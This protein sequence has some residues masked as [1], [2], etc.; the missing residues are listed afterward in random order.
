MFVG[1]LLFA[2]CCLMRAAWCSLFVI[3]CLL[4]VVRCSVIRGRSVLLRRLLL[5]GVSCSFCG[6][7]CVICCASCVA[8]CV[9]CFVLCFVFCVL[10]LLTDG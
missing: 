1:C 5:L 2:V 3:C 10:R 4:C 8:M 7:C 6:V 9:L